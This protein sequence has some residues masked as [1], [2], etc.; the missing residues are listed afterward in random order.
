MSC[1]PLTIESTA[2]MLK[3]N[4]NPLRR[5]LQ[6]EP[7]QRLAKVVSSP[8]FFCVAWVSGGGDSVPGAGG[9][10]AS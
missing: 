6:V 7:A 2:F 4:P 1:S 5:G 10:M 9:A 3:H 8:A